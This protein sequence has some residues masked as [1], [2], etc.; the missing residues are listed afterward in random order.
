MKTLL[1]TVFFLTQLCL[2]AQVCPSS[3]NFNGNGRLRV[4]FDSE[5]EADIYEDEIGNGE[6]G[7]CPGGSTCNQLIGYTATG[8]GISAG[9]SSSSGEFV[10]AVN[11]KLR[12]RDGAI[13]N[14]GD[15]FQGEIIFDFNDGSSLTCGFN[16]TGNLPIELIRFNVEADKTDAIIRWATATELNSHFI[17]LQK[18]YD[19]INFKE[20]ERFYTQENATYL[21]EYEVRDRKISREDRSYYRLYQE[22]IDGEF[23]YSDIVSVKLENGVGNHGNKDF[24]VSNTIAIGTPLLLETDFEDEMEIRIYDA[25]G[26]LIINR[27]SEIQSAAIDTHGFIPGIYFISV[28]SSGTKITDKFIIE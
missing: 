18:S 3:A 4:Y 27:H 11:E 5:A 28:I 16:A 1:T 22:D 12:L 21:K 13:G 9:Y 7:S 25:Q 26:R 14:A 20:I 2:F 15:P 10:D 17:A 23:F 24:I 19:G 8:S 6:T